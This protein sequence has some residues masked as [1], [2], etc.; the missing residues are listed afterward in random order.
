MNHAQNIFDT[1]LGRMIV[2]ADDAA[3]RRIDFEDHATA[4]GTIARLASER[5]S[6][7]R[8]AARMARNA[9]EQLREYFGGTRTDF[10]LPLLP[11]GTEFQQRVWKALASIPFGQTWSY[12]KQ[13][14][15][16]GRADAL[17]AVA[18]ANGQNPFAIVIPCHRVIGASGELRGYGGGVWRKRWL[19]D[20]EQRIVS[21]R[22]ALFVA[23]ESVDTVKLSA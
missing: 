2:V 5:R 23:E 17:R 16:M 19:I 1:P 4:D 7:G 22:G 21:P 20:Y 10:D 6:N 13:A 12:L 8:D 14:R 11:Q 3:V 18:Q 15:A 9:Q